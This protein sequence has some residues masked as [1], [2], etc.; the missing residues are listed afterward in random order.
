[1]PAI[2]PERVPEVFQRPKLDNVNEVELDL[3]L[4]MAICASPLF[5]RFLFEKAYKR[6]CTA[7]LIGAWRGSWGWAGPLHRASQRDVSVLA[8]CGV[9]PI[10]LLLVEHKFVERFQPEQAIKYRE[11][12]DDGLAAN[13]WG[14]YRTL[15]CAPDSW[16]RTCSSVGDW[17]ESVSFQEIEAWFSARK[18]TE[19]A[20]FFISSMMRQAVQKYT[21]EAK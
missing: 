17:D 9:P 8:D 15:L 2:K 6:P 16:L 4:T 20:A 12:G 5:V 1:M 19:A 14:E 13:W 3:V 21:K 10:S 18:S 7:E 11:F